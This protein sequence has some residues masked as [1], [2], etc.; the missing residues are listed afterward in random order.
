MAVVP[1]SSDGWG[2]WG[3]GTQSST[4]AVADGPA[5]PE[6]QYDVIHVEVDPKAVAAAQERVHRAEQRFETERAKGNLE[7][8]VIH[9]LH[10]AQAA[11]RL[12][13]DP[14]DILLGSGEVFGEKDTSL[15]AE[16]NGDSHIIDLPVADARRRELRRAFAERIDL[17][18]F[19]EPIMR[20]SEE[21]R[22][23]LIDTYV[24]GGPLW[25]APRRDIIMTMPVAARQVMIADL[26]EDSERI[27]WDYSRDW[28]KTE[29]DE[30]TTFAVAQDNINGIV[31]GGAP[32]YKGRD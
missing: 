11:L 29:V 26:R 2:S 1:E 12:A 21:Q 20:S 25:L 8:D 32:A 16:L 13:E 22:Q 3:G 5:S 23:Q 14:G 27:A 9:E 10:A 18:G 28:L 31:D 19:F 4:A 30:G 6:P 15:I 24:K 17:P 7:P